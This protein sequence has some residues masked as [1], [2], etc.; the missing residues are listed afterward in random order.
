M[1]DKNELLR[2]KSIIQNLQSDLSDSEKGADYYLK[3][4]LL[5]IEILTNDAY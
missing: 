5:N 3:D 1:L 2:V 4:I